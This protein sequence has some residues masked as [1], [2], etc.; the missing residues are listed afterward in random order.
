MIL[1]V[2]FGIGGGLICALIAYPHGFLA[3]FLAY[4]IGGA[5]CALIPGLLSR[6]NDRV[7]DPTYLHEQPPE[8]ARSLKSPQVQT[9][10]A[11]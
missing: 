10:T 9:E 8:I 6:S 5:L 1:V 2:L 11:A 3:A 4:S 7:I